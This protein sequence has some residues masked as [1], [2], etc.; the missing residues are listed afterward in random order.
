MYRVGSDVSSG[1]PSSR[2]SRVHFKP[3]RHPHPVFCDSGR[4]IIS[5]IFIIFY[6]DTS[7]FYEQGNVRV[8]I[9]NIYSI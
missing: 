6:Y 3:S 5:P 9:H 2:L 1:D 8:Y 7:K 4:V